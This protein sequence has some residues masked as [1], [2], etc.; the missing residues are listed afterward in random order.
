[1]TNSKG[2]TLRQYCDV[3][4]NKAKQYNF[5][6]LDLYY[7]SGITKDNISTYTADGLHPNDLGFSLIA[8]VMIEFLKNI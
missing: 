5:K 7:E 3:I 1:M 2:I 6:I 4:Y 8:N